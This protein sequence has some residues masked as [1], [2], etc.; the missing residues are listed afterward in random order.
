M[1]ELGGDGLAEHGGEGDY[2]GHRA[3][4]LANVSGREAR[5][6][7]NR[8]GIGQLDVPT[9]GHAPEQS[10][11]GSQVGGSQLG[12]EA[13]PEAVSQAFGQPGERV[14]GA[15]AREDDLLAARMKSVEGVNELLLGLFLSLE[16]LDVVDQQS[17]ETAIALLEA[18]GSVALE[19]GDEL[20]GE[21]LRGRVVQIEI[22]SM[23]A[24]IVAD[25]AQQVGLA[26]PGR[27]VEEER[28]VRV[29][30]ELGDREG[31]SMG[32]PV[33]VADDE[34][35]EGVLRAQGQRRHRGA[36]ALAVPAGLGALRHHDDAMH[37]LGHIAK[38]ALE[39]GSIASL[40]PGTDR[41]WRRDVEGGILNADGPQGIDPELEGRR[42]EAG[43][44]GVRDAPPDRGQLSFGRVGRHGARS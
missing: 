44:D 33:P 11:P 13:P 4:E 15:V 37:P 3:L 5:D 19:G 34:T 30:G 32:E 35:L 10:G 24:E 27:S 23:A 25:R 20:G 41:L 18:L 28:V 16:R 36:P 9:R 40:D 7:A 22:R 8:A 21:A 26:E 2:P 31:G 39:G 42:R 12:A 1:D 43:A 6:L 38:R 29:A 14:W 17:V